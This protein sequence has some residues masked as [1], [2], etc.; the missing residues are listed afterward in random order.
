MICYERERDVESIIE[1][2]VKRIVYYRCMTVK[3]VLM[4][5]VA[6]AA[7]KQPKIIE[8]CKE[9][10]PIFVYTVKSIFRFT[11]EMP[12]NPLAFVPERCRLDIGHV[13]NEQKTCFMLGR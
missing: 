6:L 8:D 2:A 11:T 1:I 3:D 4:R 10:T 7:T 5:V 13:E 12:R 9:V